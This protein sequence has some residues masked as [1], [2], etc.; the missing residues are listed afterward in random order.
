MLLLRSPTGMLPDNW[1]MKDEL[2]ID[3]ETKNTFADVGGKANLRKLDASFVGV[4]SYLEKK[5]LSFREGEIGQLED[6]LKNASRIV[7]FSITRFDIPVLE[8]YFEFNLKAIPVLDL[9]DEIEMTTGH[10]ISLDLLAKANLGIGK[11]NH[12][13]EAIT[14]YEQGDW[15]S[16]ERYCLNDVAITRD[17]YDLAKRQNYLLMPDR[18]TGEMV[19]VDLD[20]VRLACPEDSNTLF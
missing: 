12:A 15:A 1:T 20:P 3:I 11:T 7:G 2:V 13:L 16:L 9:L 17:L 18:A 5:L 10:R 8:K 19:R 6:R 4:Y 14:F